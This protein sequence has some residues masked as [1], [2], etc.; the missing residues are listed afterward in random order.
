MSLAKMLAAVAGIGFAAGL[1]A[2]QAGQYE[3]P[4]ETLPKAVGR[5]PILF[6]HKLHSEAGIKC[7]DCH[8]GAAKRREAGLPKLADCMVCH[9]TIATDHPEI[10]KL[11]LLVDTKVKVN[12]VRAYQVPD[13]VFFI[14]KKHVEKGET[15]ENCHGPVATRPVLAKEKSTSMTACMNCH[16][17]RGFRDECFFCHDLGQ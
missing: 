2:Q 12:W 3:S 8:P 13:C 16:A 17:E 15:C 4:P 10:A 5:Q 14:H 6:N 1:A 7:H 9:A 11:A